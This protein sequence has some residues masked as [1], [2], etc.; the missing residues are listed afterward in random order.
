MLVV[1]NYYGFTKVSR[2]IIPLLGEVIMGFK[3]VGMSG[4]T[5]A[6]SFVEGLNLAAVTC[7]DRAKFLLS[8]GNNTS[9]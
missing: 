4:Q 9:V 2:V 8:A 7:I 6:I 5:T 1:V 3:Q